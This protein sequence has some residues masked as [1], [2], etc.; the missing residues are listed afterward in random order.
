MASKKFLNFGLELKMPLE[1]EKILKQ[2]KG[3]LAKATLHTSKSTKT[4]II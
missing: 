4:K 2:K 1:E 3:C